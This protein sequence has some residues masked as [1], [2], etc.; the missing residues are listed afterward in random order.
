M[1]QYNILFITSLLFLST[2]SSCKKLVE[3]DP[4]LTSLS[5][6]NVYNENG[7][8]I[9]V[10]TGLYMQ[11]YNVPYTNDILSPASL[12]FISKIAGLSADEFGLFSGASNLMRAYYANN[13][14]MVNGGAV[15]TAGSSYGG[16]LW[17][18][19]YAQLYI[20]NSAIGGLT[21]S[22]NLTPSVKNQLLGEAKLI[23]ALYYFYLVNLWGDL[24]IVTGTDYELNRL[25]ARSPKSEVYQL[26]IE[27]LKAAKELLN[28]K[29]VD[30][31]L[32][33]YPNQS[34]AE[35]TR[36]TKWA[37]IALL[38]RTYLYVGEFAKAEAEASLIISQN[39]MFN[40]PALANV[41][42]ANSVEAIWQIQP[43]IQTWNTEDAKIFILT[44]SP[45]GFSSNKP[46][47]LS[48]SLLSSFRVGDKRRVDWVGS[49]ISGTDTFYFPHK[50]KSASSGA[51][52]TEYLSVFRLAEQ[53]L[54]RAEARGQ[55]SNIS[56]AVADLNVIR[57]RARIMP[58]SSIPD[59]LPDI[60]PTLSKEQVQAFIV[61]ERRVE[62]FSE[63]GHRWL[64]LKRTG[65]IDE[66]MNIETPLKGGSWQSYQQLYPIPLNDLLRDPNLAQ[67]TG[68]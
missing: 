2:V 37:A 51:P 10:L 36:P 13:L 29:F 53:Y 43:V 31:K 12:P 68:Y 8:A 50:Y 7:T 56:G 21:K 27:D 6:G 34:N 52:V 67:N 59:P 47:Y 66:V 16:E 61:Q 20:C 1:K 25:L 55:Q 18:K 48:N 35:R 39:S 28:D 3:V 26:I 42:L 38:A 17:S 19:C 41:F 44:A 63:W 60:L 45:A 24:P 11:L 23:R 5:S 22:I 57:K 54:I 30:I 58:N 15:A 64:D 32:N 46:I 4:P 49:Y 62:L 65:T 9:S 33:P 40:L 14:V